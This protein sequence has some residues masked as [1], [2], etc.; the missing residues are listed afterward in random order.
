MS[1]KVGQFVKVRDDVASRKEVEEE[2]GEK[3]PFTI[4]LLQYG[5]MVSE[6]GVRG[7]IVRITTHDYD[8]GSYWYDWT[9]FKV[10]N[11]IP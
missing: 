10:L 1:P 5:G 7:T 8:A 6:V 9:N 4:A 2:V 3:H 11:S